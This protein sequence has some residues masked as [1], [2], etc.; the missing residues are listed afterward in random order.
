MLSA[1]SAERDGDEVRTSEALN[2]TEVFVIIRLSLPAFPFHR[3]AAP[4]SPSASGPQPLVLNW[5]L[6]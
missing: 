5:G 1:E 2:G 4:E 3:P 6:T